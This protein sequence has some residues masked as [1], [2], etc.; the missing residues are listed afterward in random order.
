M[1]QLLILHHSYGAVPRSRQRRLIQ[2]HTSPSLIDSQMAA[3][4][5][6]PTLHLDPRANYWFELPGR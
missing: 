1:T 6:A 3:R 5:H 2:G 4:R